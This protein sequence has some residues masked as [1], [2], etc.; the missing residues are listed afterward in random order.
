MQQQWF[1]DKSNLAR[2][3]S[4]N[5]SAHLQELYTVQYSSWYVVLNTLP[6][7]DLVTEF[8]HYQITDRQRTGYN[9]P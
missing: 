8:H 6:V 7:G 1:I 5:S 3:V 2:H 4:G 9:I